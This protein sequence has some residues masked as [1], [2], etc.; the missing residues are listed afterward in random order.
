M[1]IERRAGPRRLRFVPT[2]VAL[3][4]CVICVLA[5]S[6]QHR[7][8]LEKEALQ[9]QIAMAASAAPVALPDDVADWN[10]W[11]FRSVILAGE[12]DARHQILIDNR[13]HA[14][15]AGFGVVA[16]LV[17]PD[18]RTVLIDRGFIAGGRTRA[19]LPVAPT[20]A[21]PVTI[22]GR[23]DIPPAR[24]YELGG[25]KPPAG[26]LWQH[27]DPQRFAEATGIRVLPIVVDALEPRDDGLIQEFPLPDAGIERH[28]GYMLQ[29]Y[30]FAA[31]AVGLWSWFTLR[32][33]LRRRGRA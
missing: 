25:R 18:G 1:E 30:T 6:W 32:P 11:R 9:G 15:R 17:L 13:V 29:W 24:Y 2:A 19:E 23:I 5:G 31:M 4:T 14:G 12:F 26:P 28:L 21:G 10:A 3:V 20:P 27:L 16:P 7:R 22:R 33:L 8:M